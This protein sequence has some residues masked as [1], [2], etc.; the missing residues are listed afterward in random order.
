MVYWAKIQ[1]DGQRNQRLLEAKFIWEIKEA[2]W[3]SPPVMVEKKGTKRLRMCIDFTE[4]NKHCPKDYF[5][6]PRIDQIINFTASCE[7]LPRLQLWLP[8]DSTQKRR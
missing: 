1:V 3:L 5:P 6:L 7:V 4:L 8:P 2:E